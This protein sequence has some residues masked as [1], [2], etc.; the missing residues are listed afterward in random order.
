[1]V[2]HDLLSLRQSI[3]RIKT[4][5]LLLY[6]LKSTCAIERTIY[7]VTFKHFNKTFAA[8]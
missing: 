4:A 1:M 3:A 7:S 8:S 2:F 5:V 6:C